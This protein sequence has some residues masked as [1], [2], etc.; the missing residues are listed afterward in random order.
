VSVTVSGGN[1]DEFPVWPTQQTPGPTGSSWRYENLGVVVEPSK[2]LANDIGPSVACPIWDR[3]H[4][5]AMSS[6]LEISKTLHAAR[7]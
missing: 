4:G 6:E 5:T 7:P 1:L 2:Q 3:G